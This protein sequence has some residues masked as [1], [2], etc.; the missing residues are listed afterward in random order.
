MSETDAGGKSSPEK[1]RKIRHVVTLFIIGLLLLLIA[2]IVILSFDRRQVR[3]DN[4]RTEN[5][6]VGGDRTPLSARVQGYLTRL[7]VA[8]NQAIHAGDLIATIE[9]ADYRA[10]VAQAQAQVETAEA[11]LASLDAQIQ[12][13]VEQTAQTRTTENAAKADTTRTSPELLRQ[14]RLQHTALGVQ[15]DLETAQANERVDQANVEQARA[16]VVVRERQ[17]EALF[18]QRQRQAAIVQAQRANLRLAQINLGW[19]RITAPVSGMLGPRL[20]RVG[21]LLNP[22]SEVVEVTPLD[23]VWV[24][25]NFTE[26]QIP[27]I[28][29]G[30]PAR[31]RVD[32]FPQQPLDGHVIGL[33]PTSGSI[34]SA[35]PADNTTGNFTKVVQR[36]PVRIAID[37]HGSP[38]LGLVRPGM[39]VEATVFTRGDHTTGHTTLSEPTP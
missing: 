32:S 30:Q 24:E 25:A 15:R 9:D 3:L 37:W 7:P 5:A 4:P 18:A 12:Q 13:T 39:S 1:S 10:Q 11:T 19:T 14:Q 22:G 16:Q 8:D 28:R 20:V 17:T 21:A 29:I 38:L 23:T 2:A 36:V 27:D 26:R 33:S 34:L 31:L 6:Y 35:I